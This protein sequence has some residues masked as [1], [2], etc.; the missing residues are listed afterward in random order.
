VRKIN[1]STRVLI[2]L[3]VDIYFETNQR[4]NKSTTKGFLVLFIKEK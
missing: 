4:I 2:R 1:K 3:F